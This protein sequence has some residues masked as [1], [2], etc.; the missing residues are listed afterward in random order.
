VGEIKSPATPKQLFPSLLRPV[1]RYFRG[2]R[3]RRLVALIDRLAGELARPVRVIDVGGSVTFW[4]TISNFDR[5]EVTLV[6]LPGAYDADVHPGEEELQKRVKLEIGDAR[7][8]SHWMSSGFD[9][10]IC[11]SVIEHVGSWFDIERAAG[12]LVAVAPHGWAQVPAFEFPVEPHFL[13]PFVHWFA[14]PIKIRL[15]KIFHSQ[16]RKRSHADLRK[17]CFHTNLL[18]RK[19]MRLLFPAAAHW[20]ERF[21]LIPK[22]HVATW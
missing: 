21:M 9:L 15:F 6:N 3:N 22:S 16:L 4:R 7:D 13:M 12:Q 19:E 8:L 14:D 1:S 17:E 10:V 11:N 2:R 5:C 18:T 20:S